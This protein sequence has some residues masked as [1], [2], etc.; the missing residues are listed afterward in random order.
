MSLHSAVI[1]WLHN[2][3]KDSKINHGKNEVR[4]QEQFPD[5]IKFDGKKLVEIHEVEVFTKHHY[6]KEEIKRILWLVVNN[7]W[8][9]INLLKQDTDTKGILLID[10][11][12]KNTFQLILKSQKNLD[13]CSLPLCYNSTAVIISKDQKQYGICSEHWR[14]VSSSNLEWGYQ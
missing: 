8:D 4:V 9:E 13:T 6:N 3:I 14:I 12:T 10:N 1:E 11:L 2:K 5:L 7:D